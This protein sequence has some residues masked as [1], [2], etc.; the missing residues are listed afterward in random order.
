MQGAEPNVT[1][2]PE[3]VANGFVP[4]GEEWTLRKIDVKIPEVLDGDKPAGVIAWFQVYSGRDI[5]GKIINE[6][7]PCWLG[8]PELYVYPDGIVPEPSPEPGPEPP[9]TFILT[10]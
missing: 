3:T 7:T 8:Q 9:I 1:P 4:Y 6:L 5:N 2:S 10:E